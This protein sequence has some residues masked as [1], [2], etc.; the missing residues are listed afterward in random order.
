MCLKIRCDEESWKILQNFLE[1]NP[2]FVQRG[3]VFPCKFSNVFQQVEIFY[4]SCGLRLR[5][6]ASEKC[7]KSRSWRSYMAPVALWV[8][9]EG[10]RKIASLNSGMSKRAGAGWSSAKEAPLACTQRWL[11]SAL[12]VKSLDS[13]HRQPPSAPRS[14]GRTVRRVYVDPSDWG[15]KWEHSCSC[16]VW[17]NAMTTSKSELPSRISGRKKG[18]FALVSEERM[19]L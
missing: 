7:Q 12:S 5:H 15:G 6:C 14:A 3:Q 19:I 18:G 11:E 9:E 10:E 2:A 1:L 16:R 17:T 8:R 4:R 13:A